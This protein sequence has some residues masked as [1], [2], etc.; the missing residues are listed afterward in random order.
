VNRS[1][2]ER[3][4]LPALAIAGAIA[5]TIGGMLFA[6]QA[7]T[8]PV[9]AHY[10]AYNRI[11]TAAIALLLGGALA[12]RARLVRAG[13]SGRRAIAAL[14]VGFGLVL[15]GNL[16][17]FWG[18]LI[19]GVQSSA[20]AEA[21]GGEGFW[22]S[23]PG[24]AAVLLGA[25]VVVVATVA[26]ARAAGGWPRVTMR[27]RVAIGAAGAAWALSL[28]PPVA[29]AVAAV[30]ALLFGFAWLTLALTCERLQEQTVPSTPRGRDVPQVG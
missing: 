15:A 30:P 22:G 14:A 12:V 16:L 29:P 28:N 20:A 3:V 18:A 10:D 23:D 11:Y 21:S 1:L 8:D 24:F 13:L 7:D 26:L 17:E 27:A 6:T 4:P 9:G 5:W 19:A 2:L 25:V